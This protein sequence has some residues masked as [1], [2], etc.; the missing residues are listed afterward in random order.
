MITKDEI[1]P[2]KIQNVVNKI[3]KKFDVEKI[4]LFGS[5]ATNNHNQ[6]SDLDLLIIKNTNLPRVKRGKEI[7]KQ[8]WGIGIPVD[9][10][11]YTPEEIQEWE[12]ISNSFINNVLEEGKL[13][14]E[15]EKTI[16]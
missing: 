11:V 10:V 3:V 1:T 14:Y 12:N 16:N 7:R 2:G 9:I 15:K 5:F 13:V 6:D 4:I 8:L